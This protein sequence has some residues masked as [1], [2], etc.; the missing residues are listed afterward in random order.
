MQML[1][2]YKNILVKI[3]TLLVLFNI[4]LFAN[5]TTHK[6]EITNTHPQNNL[7][8]TAPKISE[9]RE[10]E[11]G[12]LSILGIIFTIVLSSLLGAF[13]MKDEFSKGLD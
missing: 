4:T 11:L 1:I 13:F 8:A 5:T 2:N 7:V 10:V 6:E 9:N 3:V 12:S